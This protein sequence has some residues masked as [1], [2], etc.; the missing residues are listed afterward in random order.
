MAQVRQG[1][2]TDA[3]TL[4]SETLRFA[5]AWSALKSEFDTFAANGITIEQSQLDAL[6]GAGVVTVAQF[7][8]ALGAQQEVVDHI[9]VAARA[10]KLYRVRR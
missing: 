7:N 9:H 1:F 2:L 3:Q 4:I 5:D 6:F 8:A 10:A